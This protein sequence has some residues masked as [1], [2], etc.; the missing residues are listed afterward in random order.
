MSPTSATARGHSATHT[1][2]GPP[3]RTSNCRP[4]TVPSL[5]WGEK[6]S[7]VSWMVWVMF[8]GYMDGLGMVQVS[9]FEVIVCNH[10]IFRESMGLVKSVIDWVQPMLVAG[11]VT[12]HNEVPMRKVGLEHGL[13]PGLSQIQKEIKGIEGR[14]IT[15][16]WTPTPVAPSP[17]QRGR[18]GMPRRR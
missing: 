6:P 15:Q 13:I 14:E 18:S 17:K 12:R 1:P 9:D 2:R 5:L 10:C 16:G 11:R 7:P 4:L 3:G 8:M